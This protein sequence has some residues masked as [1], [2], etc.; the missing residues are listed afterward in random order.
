MIIAEAAKLVLKENGGEMSVDDIY[1]EI[2]RR[3]LF[4]F[5]AQSP[6]AVVLRTLRLKSSASENSKDVWFVLTKPRHFKLA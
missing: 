4:E 5:K 3:G 1:D 6:K 2:V